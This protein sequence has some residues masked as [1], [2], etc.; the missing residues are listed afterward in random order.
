MPAWI[1][2][3][4]YWV[5]LTGVALIAGEVGILVPR[6]A[7]LAA[8]LVGIMIFLWVLLLHIPGPWPIRISPASWRGSSRPWR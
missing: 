2:G 1:P 3:A 4:R 6:T 5:Y 8:T 7:R